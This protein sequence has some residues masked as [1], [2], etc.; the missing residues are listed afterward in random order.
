MQ[1]YIRCYIQPSSLGELQDAGNPRSADSPPHLK[2]HISPYGEYKLEAIISLAEWHV[3][4]VKRAGEL[5][6]LFLSKN[7]NTD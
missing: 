6:H 1:S 2:A 4:H 7:S 5:E 3:E